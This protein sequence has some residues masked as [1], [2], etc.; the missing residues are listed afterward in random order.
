MEASNTKTQELLLK[1]TQEEFRQITLQKLKATIGN[2]TLKKK[3][4]QLKE[5]KQ[6]FKEKIIQ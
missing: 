2:M 5:E 6:R 1:E 3:A 4:K